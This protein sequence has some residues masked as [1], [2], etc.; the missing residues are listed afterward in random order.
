[1]S[2]RSSGRLVTVVVAALILSAAAAPVIGAVAPTSDPTQSPQ[3][4]SGPVYQQ[5]VDTDSV[6]L[7]VSVNENG[8]ATWT[9]QY[10]TRLDD[11]NTTAAFESL[12]SDIEANPESFSDR[13]ASRMQSTVG[14]A[15]N[16]TGREMNASDFDV[17]AE[18]RA[19]PEYGVVIYTFHWDGFA[20]VDGDTI[21]VGDAIEGIFLDDRTRLVVEWPSTYATTDVTPA[22]D[23]RREDAV[24]WRGA[25]T[26]F[27]SGEP[28]VVLRP[29]STVT[30]SA[31]G[32]GG[33]DGTVSPTPDGGGSTLPLLGI[34][35]LFVV[36]AAAWRYRDRFGDRGAGTAADGQAADADGDGADDAG[37]TTET[38]EDLLSNEERVLQ[39]VREHGGRVKQQEIV[40]AFDWT[41]AR[42]SQIVRDLRDEGELEG[43]RLGRENVLKLP[44][45]DDEQ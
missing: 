20:A 24:V 21:R 32:G 35:F 26:S 37:A 4:D 2:E 5:G 28:S 6:R 29:A 34:G 7:I 9:V 45:G 27:V 36:V 8:S 12:Q 31:A 25:E 14:T 18:T 3:F 19:P 23:E 17:R 30:T 33:G 10:W 39:F 1:M 38:R 22:P 15:E 16:A 13:F 42:T 44:D 40:E 11:E 43:F 41:E